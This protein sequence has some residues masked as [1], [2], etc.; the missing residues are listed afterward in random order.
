MKTF[1]IAILTVIGAILL[2]VT[3]PLFGQT[4]PEPGAAVSAV[5]P[6]TNYTPSREIGMRPE[7]KRSLSLKVNERNPYA[8]RSAKEE[9][10]LEGTENE[11]ELRLRDMLS[12]LSVTGRSRGPN[13]L[14]VLLGDI[15]LE[16]GKVL[17]QLIVDQSE[18]LQ[19]IEVNEDTVILGWLDIETGELTG[20]TTQVAYDLSPSIA[21]ALHGQSA[22]E[23]SKDGKTAERR[24]GVLRIGQDRKRFESEMAAKDPSKKVP[25]EVYQAGQ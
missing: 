13:G 24:M 9:A 17:P 18:Q 1:Y 10:E 5:A 11:E 23:V 21:Y 19:V 20:K 2:S 4:A 14:R 12:S 25:Q 8:K 15:I 22:G 16:R 7:D 3:S 6:I